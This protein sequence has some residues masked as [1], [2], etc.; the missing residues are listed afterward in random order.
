MPRKTA[1]NDDHSPPPPTQSIQKSV[2]RYPSHTKGINEV[3]D[4]NTANHIKKPE[5]LDIREIKPN[6]TEKGKKRN[7]GV[8]CNGKPQP[9]GNKETDGQSTRYKGFETRTTPNTLTDAV[10]SLT[11]QQKVAVGSM[12]LDG[13]LN[14][15]ITY[16]PT[17]FAIWLLEA[18][19][20]K[21]CKLVTRR[22]DAEIVPMDV[23]FTLGLPMGGRPI[24]VPLRTN[25]DA[26]LVQTFRRQYGDIK[27]NKIKCRIMSEKIQKSKE[28]N[29]L[30]KLN[31]LV[32]FYS[33]IV[34]STT[35]GKA[36]QRIL[37]A[38]ERIDDIRALNWGE[39]FIDGL[40]HTKDEWEVKKGSPYTGPMPFL[41]VI[42]LKT[43]KHHAHNVYALIAVLS[44]RYCTWTDFKTDLL[45][46]REHFLR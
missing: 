41:M 7:K 35:S 17:Q 23:N 40:R 10:R 31:F 39:F 2:G 33:T 22:G 26:L 24:K 25:P 30:F 14:L 20:S 43:Q 12:G 16:V 21:E 42:F 5:S 45:N 15:G 8:V 6:Q 18:F 3:V 13:M 28:A 4:T 27:E 19:D 9:Q 44:R 32:L 34:D 46:L 38:I 37:N 1:N 29:D 36:N 11:E